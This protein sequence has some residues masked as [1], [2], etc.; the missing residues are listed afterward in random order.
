MSDAIIGK[1]TVLSCATSS[2]GSYTP[3]AEVTNVQQPPREVAKV[4]ATHYGSANNS[5]EYINGVW[6]DNGDIDFTLNYESSQTNTINGLLGVERWFRIV[7]PDGSYWQF[8]GAIGRLG[9]PIPIDNVITQDCRLNVLDTVTY[10]G[11][12]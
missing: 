8:H 10:N 3:L 9:G 5:H 7:M 6:I 1:G 11:A 2:G 12:S 4:R